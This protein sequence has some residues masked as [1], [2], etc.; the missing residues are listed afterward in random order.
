[1][2]AAILPADQPPS[3]EAAAS[4]LR[5]GKL[6]AFPTETVYGL[7]A[8]A[9]SDAAV[10]AIYAA[11]GRPSHNPLI[12]HLPDAQAAMRFGRFDD[13]A[14][15]LASAF[16]PGP[17]TLVVPCA[18]GVA[19]SHLVTAGLP[20]VALRVP[21]HPV[22]LALLKACGLPLAAPSANVSG[23]VSATTAQHVAETLADKVAVILDGGPSH[24]G[25]ES[26]IVGLAGDRPVL[27]RPGGV[28]REAIEALIG[29]LDEPEAGLVAAPGMLASHYAPHCP[30]RLDV[31]NPR[32]DEALLAFGPDV[33]AGAKLVLNLS[34]AGD[35]EEAAANLYAHLR[36]L[37]R[38]DAAAIAVMPIPEHG[39]GHAINDRLRRAAAPRDG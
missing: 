31:T 11:K 14:A 38:A 7:G 34:P 20:T 10:A 5:Q 2:P 24:V 16:W 9:G 32:A 22:A 36:A 39:L 12:V 25:V 33:P 30:V 13:R 18:D 8:D 35:L 17:L 37:D 3:I 15:R 27:L 28:P 19:L 6:V 21:S 4:A 29:P 26:T 23:R 1:M